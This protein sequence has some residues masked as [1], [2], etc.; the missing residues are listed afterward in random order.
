MMPVARRLTRKNR[1]TSDRE[2]AA[3][4]RLVLERAHRRA[5]VASTGRTRCR[6][7]RS[8]GTPRRLGMRRADGVDHGDGVGA[9]LL[10]DAQEDAAL[11]VDAHDLGLVGGAVLDLG[12]VGDAHRRRRRRRPGRPCPART[13][14][15]LERRAPASTWVLVKTL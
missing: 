6:A 12:H 9:R 3:L 1:M 5:D 11:A 13:T 7:S 2:Q 10:E 14:T 4:Q 8:A 15:S